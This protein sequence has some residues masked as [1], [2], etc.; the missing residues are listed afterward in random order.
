MTVLPLG[1]DG[2][3]SQGNSELQDR[4]FN[5]FVAVG[6]H[7]VLVKDPPSGAA[8]FG[9]RQLGDTPYYAH[10]LAGHLLLLEKSYDLQ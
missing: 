8:K 3:L 10:A 9:W 4:V 1:Q 2:M 7:P 5:P 6:A